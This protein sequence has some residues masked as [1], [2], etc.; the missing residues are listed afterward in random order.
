[1]NLHPGSPDWPDMLKVARSHYATPPKDVPKQQKQIARDTE[2]PEHRV[3]RLLNAAHRSGAIDVTVSEDGAVIDRD[4]SRQLADS[5]AVLDKALVVRQ[6]I[7]AD[8]S[9]KLAFS[10][11]LHSLLARRMAAFLIDNARDGDRVG[12]GSGRGPY[13]TCYYMGQDRS[14]AANML[15]SFTVI[16]LTGRV[17]PS[18][19]VKPLETMMDAD[20]AAVELARICAFPTVELANVPIGLPEEYRVDSEKTPSLIL[21]KWRQGMAPNWALVGIGS[22]S[23]G[24]RYLAESVPPELRALKDSIGKLKLELQHFDPDNCPVGD[25]CN[26]LFVIQDAAASHDLAVVAQ[27][28]DEV[29]RHLV[30]VTDEHLRLVRRV[31]VVAGGVAKAHAI[32]EVLKKKA[33]RRV[34]LCTDSE[35]A[36]KLLALETEDPIEECAA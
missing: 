24:H 10:D 29:N 17:S 33:L 23:Y 31:Y 6:A 1:M 3:G 4:L 5:Y 30:C 22:L 15:Q 25:L 18:G 35:C 20:Q 7:F 21:S 8:R 16:P 12:V 28:V 11:E 19:W 32:R 36:Q 34:V 9:N 27:L 14:R 26:R 2:I 13:L